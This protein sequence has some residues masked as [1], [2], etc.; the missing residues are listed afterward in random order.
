[1]KTGWMMLGAALLT[2]GVAH[3][4]DRQ[5]YVLSVM[6]D[7]VA[8]QAQHLW[9]VGNKAFDDD[10]NPDVSK[11]TDAEWKKLGGA[12]AAMKA[13]ALS[14]ADAPKVLV[15]AP[16]TKLQDENAP[17]NATAKQIQ[18]FIDANPKDYA[19]HARAL[20]DVSDGFLKASQTKDAKTLADASAKLD[21]VCE[22]CHVKY[23]YPQ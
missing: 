1:M 12:A 14:M 23:W 13:A 11:V 8:P 20:A 3:A 7:I 16:G 17:G 22:A 6:K 15:A 4:A 10:G 9:D 2:M 18:A 19:D 21:E 5:V